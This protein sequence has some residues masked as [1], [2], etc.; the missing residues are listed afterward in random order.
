MW[1]GFFPFTFMVQ[2]IL[3]TPFRRLFNVKDPNIR[4]ILLPFIS[5][6][7]IHWFCARRDRIIR[8]RWKTNP[9]KS[10]FMSFHVVRYLLVQNR[11]DADIIISTGFS[12]KPFRNT[13]RYRVAKAVML[14]VSFFLFWIV[15]NCMSA[16]K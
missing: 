3:K 1:W 13:P 2:C 16:K 11:R 4:G 8:D 10:L 14:S 7:L 9:G 5:L 12:F 6:Y 15:S